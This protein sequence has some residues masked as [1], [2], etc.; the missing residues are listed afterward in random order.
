[1]GAYLCCIYFSLL[2]FSG[3]LVTQ[4][5]WD[6]GREVGSG[7][8]NESKEKW[9]LSVSYLKSSEGESKPVGES[10]KHPENRMEV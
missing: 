4:K 3:K 6:R 2:F 7:L 1:M 8:Y 10:K 5:H 9:F